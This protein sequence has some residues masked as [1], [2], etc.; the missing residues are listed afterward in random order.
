MKRWLIV[1][2]AITAA[3]VGLIAFRVS[4]TEKKASSEQPSPEQIQQFERML[5]SFAKVI[6]RPMSLQD[7]GQAVRSRAG[8]SVEEL[9]ADEREKLF[10]CIDRFYGC[11]SSGDFEAYKQFRMRPP[12]TVGEGVVSAVEQIASE[13][14]LPVGSDEEVLHIAWDQYNSTNRIGE[15]DDHSITLKIVERPNLGL[16]FFQPSNPDVKLPGLGASCWGGGVVYQPAPAELLE[17]QGSL[18][19]FTLECS[20][21]FSPFKVGP[22]TP[23]VLACYWDPTREDWMP[24]AMCTSFHIGDYRTA[25]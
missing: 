9:S 17:K 25:F 19:F 12:F 22:A 24:Y 8:T 5:E 2:L 13:R 4:T 18:R 6:T 16:A 11:Y 15:V 10:A 23:L 7:F 21:R 14:G 3:L 20:V 1:S